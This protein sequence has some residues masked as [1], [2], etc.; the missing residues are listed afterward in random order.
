M[1]KHLSSAT[2]PEFF[3]SRFHSQGMKIVASLIIFVFLIPY[4]AS[5]YNGLS[6]LFGMAFD[7]PYSVCVMGMAILTAVYVILGGYMATAINDFIQGII[8]LAGIAAIILSVLS[9]QGGFTAAVGRL[10][11]IPSEVPVTLASRS[12]HLLLRT[13]SPEPA[14]RG[15][16]HLPWNLGPAP[17]DSQI[18]YHPKRKSHCHGHGDF[19]PV[20]HCHLRG[21]LFPGRLRPAL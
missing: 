3:G 4:T 7:I 21:Q 6:R 19:H 5:V 17:D 2:M 14:G 1:S 13:G 20:C 18:L 9:G 15:D 16:S 8:M 11:Q 12:L 10:A